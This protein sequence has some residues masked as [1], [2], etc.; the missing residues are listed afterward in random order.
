MSRGLYITRLLVRARRA[1]A[2]H[3]D[4]RDDPRGNLP[5]RERPHH[6]PGQGPALHAEHRRRAR[7]TCVQVSRERRLELGEGESGVL[8]PWLHIGSVHLLVLALS[9]KC[10]VHD[11]VAADRAHVARALHEKRLPAVSRATARTSTRSR[12]PAGHPTRHQRIAAR[13]A[14][15]R[16]LRSLRRRL[17]SRAVPT[18]S[19]RSTARS[20]APTARWRSTPSSI[21]PRCCSRIGR[22]TTTSRCS[23]SAA[24]RRCSTSRL[25]GTLWQ[26]VGTMRRNRARPLPAEHA[27]RGDAPHR[28]RPRRHDC[29][30]SRAAPGRREQHASPGGARPRAATSS[31]PRERT[32]ASSRRSS[33]RAGASSSESSAIRRSCI[34]NARG[35]SRLFLDFVA[36]RVGEGPSRTRGGCTAGSGSAPSRCVAALVVVRNLVDLSGSPPGLYVDEASIGYNAW[37]IAHYGVDEHGIHFPLFFEAFGEYKNPIYV[38]AVA[39]LV[40]FLPLTVA[41]ER[42]SR[43]ALRARGGRVPHR[44][45]VA[46]HRVTADHARHARSHGAHPVA[47]HREPGRIRDHLDGRVAL[48]GALVPL[49]RERRRRASSGF[50]GVFLAFAIYGYTT[51]RLEILLLA[52]ALGVAWGLAR[53]AGWWRALVPVAAGYVVLGIYALLNPG[54]LTG[55]FTLISIWSDGAPLGVVI[56]RFLVNYVSYFSA[57]LSVPPRRREPASE[58]RDRRHAPLGDGAAAHRGAWS[59][60]GSGGASRWCDSSSRAILL[61][62]IAAA[63]TN[64]GTPHALR[65]SGML[66]FL[67]VLAVLGADGLR[68]A[69]PDGPGAAGSLSPACSARACSR[70]RPSSPSTSTRPTR[71]A[72]HRSSTPARPRRSS[73]RAHDRAVRTGSSCPTTS[74]SHTSKR[75]SRYSRP[76]RRTRRPTTPP[77]G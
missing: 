67:V 60:A 37:T 12:A 46:P 28:R 15:A 63:L 7:Q 19:R 53:T 14:A 70:R 13:A 24:A 31:S 30:P 76:R 75:S 33:I 10:R 34:S 9:A 29:T 17:P 74:T 68:S 40:R 47:R 56:D 20:C 54:A 71:T 6:P 5:H 73:P 44:R 26:D 50:A 1:S 35:H 51:A 58:H 62:P 65:S 61:A 4:H 48:G 77:R 55:R 27:R 22:S 59:C 32:T 52:I 16:A 69:W 21:A 43:R 66:P 38:Y 49:R 3:R 64:N 45:R 41:V 57:E 23:P 42:V 39:A 8:S 72:R 36:A 11:T 18:S 2:A 25:G